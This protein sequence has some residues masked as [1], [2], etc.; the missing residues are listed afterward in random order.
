MWIEILSDFEP[1]Q[2]EKAFSLLK[3]E[4]PNFSYSFNSSSVYAYFPQEGVLFEERRSWLRVM[5]NTV[6]AVTL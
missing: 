4:I 3:K 1:K 6:N 5:R 2:A